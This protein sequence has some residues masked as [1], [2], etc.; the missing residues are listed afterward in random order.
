MEKVRLYHKNLFGSSLLFT[1]ESIHSGE[2]GTRILSS[3][4]CGGSGESVKA[5]SQYPFRFR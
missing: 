5:Q 1:P 4:C 3:N 2:K